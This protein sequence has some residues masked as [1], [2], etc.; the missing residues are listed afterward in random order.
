MPAVAALANSFNATLGAGDE[1]YTARR[2]GEYCFGTEA[3]L[4]VLV[5]E[6]VGK[7]RGYL[8]YYRAFDPLMAAPTYWAVDLFVAPDWR[9]RGFGMGLMSGIAAAAVRDGMRSLWWASDR[10]DMRGQKF[11]RALGARDNSDPVFVLDSEQLQALAA[12]HD[13]MKDGK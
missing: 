11:Y 10:D 7:V 9:G 2:L 6:A 1:R 3:F 12:R 13:E 4:H 8:T 5:A